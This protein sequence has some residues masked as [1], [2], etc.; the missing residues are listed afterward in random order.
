MTHNEEF[1]ERVRADRRLVILRYL[2]EEPDGRMS[3]SLMVDALD[4]MAHRVSRATVMADACWLEEQ[5]L[6]R[7]EYIQSVPMLRITSTGAEVARGVRLVPGVKR[8]ARRD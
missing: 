2:D 5:G 3:V 6:L 4:V 1:Q 7:L 8:P